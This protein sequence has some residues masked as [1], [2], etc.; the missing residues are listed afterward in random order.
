MGIDEQLIAL[1]ERG[2][3]DREIGEKLGVSG[4]VARNHRIKL[5]L[6]AHGH[7]RLFTDQQLIDLYER[8]LNDREI[9]EELDASEEAV[10][11]HRIKLGIESTRPQREPFDWNKEYPATLRECVEQGLPDSDIAKILGSTRTTVARHRRELGPQFFKYPKRLFTDEQLIMLHKEGLN[12]REIGKRL[13]AS[14]P[15]VQ[16]HR[17]RLGLKVSREHSRNRNI[18]ES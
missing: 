13:G 1:H 16:R 2:L 14:E 15:T 17:S 8:G 3:N 10:Y 5:G 4:P 6:K 12:D 18:S 11:Y 9:G 7:K